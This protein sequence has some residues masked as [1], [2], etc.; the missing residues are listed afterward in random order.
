MPA[1]VDKCVRAVGRKNRKVN[2]WAVCVSAYQKKK[3]GTR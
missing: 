2:P 1:W 3:G